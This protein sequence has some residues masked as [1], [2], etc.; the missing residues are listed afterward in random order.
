MSEMGYPHLRPKA[1]LGDGVYASDD[2]YHIVLEA[3]ENHRIFLDGEV[4]VSLFKYIAKGKGWADH[5][6]KLADEIDPPPA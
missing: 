1:Y 5:L 6:R 2:G 4:R 3:G